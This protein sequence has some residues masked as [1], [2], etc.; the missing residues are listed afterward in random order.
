MPDVDAELLQDRGDQPVVLPQ[1]RDQQVGGCHLGV[2]ALRGER[3]RRGDGFLRL[4]REA[5]R[6]H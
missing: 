6:L 2:A 3:L 1:Q 4:D 5:I